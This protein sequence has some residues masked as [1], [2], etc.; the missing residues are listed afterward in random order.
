MVPLL[1]SHEVH[2]WIINLA[3]SNH[4]EQRYLKIL[5]AEEIAQANKF[6]FLIHRKRFIASHGAL[7]HILSNYLQCSA[8]LIQFNYNPHQKPHLAQTLGDHT[9]TLLPRLQF[10][11]AHSQDIALLALTLDH[12]LGVDIEKIN[13]HLPAIANRYFTTQENTL[14]DQ[15]QSTEKNNGFY[16]IWVRKETITK[17]IGKGLSFGLSNFSVSLSENEMIKIE[18]TTWNIVPLSIHPDYQ[19]A[20]ASDQKI[21][22]ILWHIYHTEDGHIVDR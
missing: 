3:I 19:A 5:N 2:L 9:E 6:R 18:D 20:L 7:R 21:N 10:N 17:A 16:A 15:L 4:Q 11:L 8:H 12:H 22:R 14:L 1:S 13:D